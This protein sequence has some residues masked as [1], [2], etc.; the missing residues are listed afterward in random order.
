M[1]KKNRFTLIELLTIIAIIAILVALL[2]PA[3]SMARN[4]FLALSCAGQQRQI[5]T[6]M[7]SYSLDNNNVFP[8]SGG[9]QDSYYKSLL[10]NYIDTKSVGDKFNSAK[11][12]S[13]PDKSTGFSGIGGT[14]G[15]LGRASRRI[16]AFRDPSTLAVLVDY[17]EGNLNSSYAFQNKIDYQYI[18]GASIYAK[19]AGFDIPSTATANEEEFTRGRHGRTVAV[20]F[21]DGGVKVLP[22]WIAARDY[23][24]KGRDKEADSIFRGV[25]Y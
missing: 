19:E 8:Y 4:H 11:I 6:A 1:M 15:N 17:K 12:Y 7:K 18:P 13:C 10:I 2:M 9:Y 20:A 16:N 21:A 22:A 14:I 25:N 23:H 5:I 24:T 3:L